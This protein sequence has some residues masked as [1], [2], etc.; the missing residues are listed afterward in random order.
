MALKVEILK[1]KDDYFLY[2]DDYLWMWDIEIERELQKEIADKA[3]GSVL[4]AGYGLGI[5]QKYLEKNPNVNSVLTIEKYAE[6][7][8]ANLKTFGEMHGHVHISD[9]YTFTTDKKFD[10]VIGDVWKEI[11]PKCLDEY[12]KFKIKSKELLRDNGQIF[13]WGQEYFEYLIGKEG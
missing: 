8:G 10:C 7:F 13:A 3:Y 9:F 1:L 12:K 4:V 6:V 5:V 2:I 11:H